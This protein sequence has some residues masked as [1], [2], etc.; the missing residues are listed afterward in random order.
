MFIFTAKFNKKKAVALVLA[1]AALLI[2]IVLIAGSGDRSDNKAA[3]TA[4]LSAIVKNNEQRVNYLKAL[5]WE[6]EPTVLE[7]QKIVIPRSFTDV[8]KKYNE[9]QLAQGFDLSKYGGEEAMRYTYRILNH[10]HAA[11]TVVADIIVYKNEVIAG[12]VQ[13]NALDG[14]M[15][16]LEYPQTDAPAEPSAG[17][18]AGPSSSDTLTAEDIL[19]SQSSQ[20]EGALTPDGAASE[21]LPAEETAAASP[22]L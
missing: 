3:E 10:P 14:F 11:G 20:A 8:Y 22:A 19:T 9:I 7:Q 12:D 2:A 1:L 21:A 18:A 16:G 17:S 5:G 6:V 13:S 15:A 4:A